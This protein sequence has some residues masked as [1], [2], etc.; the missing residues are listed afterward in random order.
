MG[1]FCDNLS[2]VV[3]VPRRR[4]VTATAFIHSCVSWMAFCL[5]CSQLRPVCRPRFPYVGLFVAN[6]LNSLQFLVALV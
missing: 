6:S 2:A 5:S 3:L 4:K 1:L